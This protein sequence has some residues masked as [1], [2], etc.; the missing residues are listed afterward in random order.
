MRAILLLVVLG[1][2]L[3]QNAVARDSVAEF[4][5]EVF[6]SRGNLR[7]QYAGIYPELVNKTK[8]ERK[9]FIANSLK[10]YNG[11]NALNDIPLILTAKEFDSIISPGVAQRAR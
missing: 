8:G 1:V 9:E 2:I 5:D 7:P 4:Y 11:D 6:D 3:G 10:A